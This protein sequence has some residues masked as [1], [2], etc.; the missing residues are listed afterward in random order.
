MKKF[1]EMQVGMCFVASDVCTCHSQD[2]KK[3]IK[4]VTLGGTQTA[5][6]NGSG[7]RRADDVGKCID[8]KFLIRVPPT[9]YALMICD[10][11]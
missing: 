3:I 4:K 10:A 8:H 5:L 7:T 9:F 1:G 2:H 6:S 11:L